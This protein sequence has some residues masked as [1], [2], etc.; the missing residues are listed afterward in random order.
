MWILPAVGAALVANLA[1]LFLVSFLTSERKPPQDITDPVGVNLVELATPEAPE[2][3]EPKKPEP[4]KPKPQEDFM[5]DLVRPDLAG[6][7][8]LIDGIAIDLSR[9]GGGLTEDE[10]V[11]ESYELDQPPQPITKIPPV[12]PYRARERGIEGAVQVK[13]LVNA[14][15]SVSRI[16]ILD[17]RPAGLFEEAVLKALPQWRFQPGVIDGQPVTAWVVTT[18]HFT[19]D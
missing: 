1:L 19:L 16:Q 15:G 3:Q 10:F 4:P 6:P 7:G 9:L 11:F 8:S 5:P 14:D 2:R 18:L 12:Y 17:A 13:L